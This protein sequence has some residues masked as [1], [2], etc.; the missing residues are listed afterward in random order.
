M[1]TPLLYVN[2][3]ATILGYFFLASMVLTLFFVT[4]QLA[5]NL[6]HDRQKMRYEKNFW[7]REQQRWSDEDE[8]LSRQI[9]SLQHDMNNFQNRHE[10][11]VLDDFPSTVDM[12][13]V[14]PISEKEYRDERSRIRRPRK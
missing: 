9:L 2:M 10:T 7:E 1:P 11:D 12:R 3:A 8:T 14:T 4:A 5:L 6:V 13:A